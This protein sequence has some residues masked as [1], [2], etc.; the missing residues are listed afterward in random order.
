MISKM[1][2][3]LNNCTMWGPQ[4]LK[5]GLKT[6]LNIVISTINHSE[7]GLICTNL[8]IVWGPHIVDIY[9]YIYHP[10]K[11]TVVTLE[12]NLRSN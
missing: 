7:M 11:P 3:N 4:T 5:V 8:A 6:P 12:L 1:A 9:K 2:Y 10:Q